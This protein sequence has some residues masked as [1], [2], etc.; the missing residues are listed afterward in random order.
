M[1]HF[2]LDIKPYESIKEPPY[3]LLSS[4]PANSVFWQ[5][6]LYTICPPHAYM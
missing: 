1:H 4:I 2:S 3:T 5:K 6:V